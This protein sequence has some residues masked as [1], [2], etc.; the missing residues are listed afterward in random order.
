VQALAG[1]RCFAQVTSSTQMTAIAVAAAVQGAGLLAGA[2]AALQRLHLHRA[3]AQWQQ[4]SYNH[5][6]ALQITK[7]LNPADQIQQHVVRQETRSQLA[8]RPLHRPTGGPPDRY[9]YG[10]DPAK[11]TQCSADSHLQDG[12]T[13]SLHCLWLHSSQT[14]T[15]LTCVHQLGITHHFPAATPD[16]WPRP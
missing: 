1:A 5:Q 14:D 6:S 3:A 15:C 12:G 10:R 8:A 4:E 16:E 2:I 11:D 13:V 7:R 9:H